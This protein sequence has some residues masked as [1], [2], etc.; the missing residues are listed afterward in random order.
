[1][2]LG[3][4]CALCV[5]ICMQLHQYIAGYNKFSYKKCCTLDVKIKTASG[6]GPFICGFIVFYKE[7]K[8]SVTAEVSINWVPKTLKCNSH[9]RK[10]LLE[11]CK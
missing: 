9:C 5:V 3:Q 4:V 10:T 6:E 11:K 1:M 8:W 7:G 2:I